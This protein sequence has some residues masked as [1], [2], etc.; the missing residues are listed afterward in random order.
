MVRISDAR[1]SG[2]SYGTVILHVAPE[3]HVGGPLSLVRDGDWIRLDV[4]VRCLE[5]EITDAELTSRRGVAA[6]SSAAVG[7]P[8]P[9]SPHDVRADSGPASGPGD[10]RRVGDRRGDRYNTE[11]GVEVNG[12]KAHPTLG[13]VFALLAAQPQDRLDLSERRGPSHHAKPPLRP[14][15]FRP[16][17]AP[18]RLGRWCGRISDQDA[19]R[20][21]RL[22]LE[23]EPALRHVTSSSATSGPVSQMMGTHRFE[24]AGGSPCSSWNGPCAVKS[25]GPASKRLTDCIEGSRDGAADRCLRRLAAWPPFRERP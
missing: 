6:S 7:T 3:A 15:T 2:T 8:S 20:E 12:P 23:A 5:V 14:R 24:S 19:V 21:S 4:P 22:G 17:N 16:S 13:A 10:R 1:M 11:T 9:A 18:D 25:S